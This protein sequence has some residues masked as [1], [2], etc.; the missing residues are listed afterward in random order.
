MQFN[1]FPEYAYR[2]RPCTEGIFKYS[3]LCNDE[4]VCAFM[5]LETLEIFI[6]RSL[7]EKEMAYARI[8]EIINECF[9]EY[10]AFDDALADQEKQAKREKQNARTTY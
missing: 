9:K 7:K 10:R 2:I 4:Q 5:S 6:K 1:L 8:M 3:L